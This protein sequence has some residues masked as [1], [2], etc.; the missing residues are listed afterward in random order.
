[1][2]Q[3]EDQTFGCAVYF[4]EWETQ[5][6]NF[7]G[8]IERVQKAREKTSSVQTKEGYLWPSIKP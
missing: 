4:I 6:G 3:L 1:M 7:H 2:K 8:T 5:I